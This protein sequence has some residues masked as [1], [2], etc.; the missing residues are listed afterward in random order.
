M[1]LPYN[2]A[3][4]LKVQGEVKEKLAVIW[5]RILRNHFHFFEGGD[6]LH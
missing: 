6:E 4:L 2:S 5:Q 3:K 1:T